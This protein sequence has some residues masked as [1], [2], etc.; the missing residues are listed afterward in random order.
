MYTGDYEDGR[1]GLDHVET[2][3]D[4]SEDEAQKADPDLT[5]VDEME[6]LVL[7]VGLSVGRV[8]YI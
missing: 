1:S 6:T 7:A 5:I 3:S 2:S 8:L 4:T